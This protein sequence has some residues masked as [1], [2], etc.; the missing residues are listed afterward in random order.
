VEPTQPNMDGTE[1]LGSLLGGLEELEEAVDDATAT[2]SAKLQCL[3]FDLTDDGA[4]P[5]ALEYE[6]GE[7]TRILHRLRTHALIRADVEAA[8]S[9]HDLRAEHWLRFLRAA[10]QEGSYL[11]SLDD[12]LRPR[13]PTNALD[14]YAT[15]FRAL[16]GRD[17][18]AR[19]DAITPDEVGTPR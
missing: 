15:M 5:L 13:L 11:A 8:L 7:C 12:D 18:D 4:D 10:L 9:S 1:A 16:A 3:Q 2:A 6:I 17:F 14:R 19:A